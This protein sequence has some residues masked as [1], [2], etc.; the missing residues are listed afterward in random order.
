MN[1]ITGSGSIVGSGEKITAKIG[2]GVNKEA[3]NGVVFSLGREGAEAL[4][5]GDYETALD[6][7]TACCEVNEKICKK[8]DVNYGASLHNMATALHYLGK[9]EQA[10]LYY[11]KAKAVFEK[12]AAGPFRPTQKHRIKFIE[13]RLT[14]LR[15]GGKPSSETYIDEYGVERPTLRRD[16]EFDNPHV[17]A[18][19]AEKQYWKGVTHAKNKIWSLAQECFEDALSLA[20][21]SREVPEERVMLCHNNLGVVLEEQG[22]LEGALEH[23]HRAQRM[24]LKLP[25]GPRGDPDRMQKLRRI[26]QRI[27]TCEAQ[28]RDPNWRRPP[29]REPRP[30]RED[31]DESYP[32][33]GRGRSDSG[34]RG[35]SDSDARDRGEASLQMCSFSGPRD[36]PHRR[37]DEGAAG[38]SRGRYGDSGGY[39]GRRRGSGGDGGRYRDSDARGRE[40]GG[41]FD[42]VLPPRASTL[43]NLGKDTSGSSAGDKHGSGDHSTYAGRG[44][45]GGG[46]GYDDHPQGRDD[47]R[48]RYGGGDWRGYGGGRGLAESAARGGYADRPSSSRAGGGYGGGRYRDNEP[49]ES[50]QSR[51]EPSKEQHYYYADPGPRHGPAETRA[52][53]YDP[54]D[55]LVGGDSPPREHHRE[56]HRGGYGAHEGDYAYA[57]GGGVG[58]GG[59]RRG[60]SRSPPRRGRAPSPSPRSRDEPH[61]GRGYSNGGRRGGG[62]SDDRGHGN[63]RYTGNYDEY[64]TRVNKRDASP[65]GARDRYSLDRGPS[66]PRRGRSD[67]DGGRRGGRAGGGEAVGNLLDLDVPPAQPAI[68]PNASAEDIIDALDPLKHPHQAAPPVPAPALLPGAQFGLDTVGDFGAKPA[69]APMGFG[70]APPMGGGGS[71]PGVYGGGGFG[72]G[73]GAGAGGP[74]GFAD[75][76]GQGDFSGGGSGNGYGG[77][78]GGQRSRG[79]P[80]PYREPR[81]PADDDEDELL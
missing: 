28:L 58:R 64:D 52:Q 54:D 72:G 20:D 49:P 36:E 17:L 40:G 35:R 30:R 44:G 39:D 10:E 29:P 66:P 48:D 81:H 33:G 15:F 70:D 46:R 50:P 37:E 1:A 62:Y 45:G 8:D 71:G 23:L 42:D 18:Q 43:I 9:L 63:G 27:D 24:M 14:L 21:Q 6:R 12:Q 47:D 59:S 53:R 4:R 78:N 38:P 5:K 56:G 69:P 32:G 57:D 25:G 16:F 3:L 51:D 22:D 55:D 68:D 79:R 75:S 65:R 11:E 13:E 73:A 41:R 7:F 77:G 74:T 2:S 80:E 60:Y 26:E 76:F 34:G 19:R 61:F 31:S 67:S